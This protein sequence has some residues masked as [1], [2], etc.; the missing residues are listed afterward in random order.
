MYEFLGTKITCYNKKAYDKTNKA[1][2]KNMYNK[3]KGC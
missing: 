3:W 2:N 1:E